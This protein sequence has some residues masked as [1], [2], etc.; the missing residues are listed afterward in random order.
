MKRISERRGMPSHVTE[1]RRAPGRSRRVWK[2]AMAK[3]HER[4]KTPQWARSRRK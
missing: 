2:R 4:S 3:Q 1:P